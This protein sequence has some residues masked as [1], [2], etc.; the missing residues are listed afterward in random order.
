MLH[1]KDKFTIARS[2][3]LPLAEI[4][5]ALVIL[6]GTIAFAAYTLRE[7]SREQITAQ[8]GQILYA[9][10]LSQKF[11]EDPETLLDNGENAAAQLPAVLLT[12]RLP[13]LA[14]LWG[15]R[16]FDANGKFVYADANLAE[17]TL[18]PEQLTE[19]QELRPVA[20]LRQS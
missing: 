14:G 3:F 2:R 12:A 5:L 8:H 6:A 16:L 20:R 18:P 10:W 13:Q 7:Q 19:L 1:K 15:T 11:S 9:L 4:A 17:S